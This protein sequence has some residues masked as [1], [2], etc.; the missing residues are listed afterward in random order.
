MAEPAESGSLARDA[1][2]GTRLA[3]TRAYVGLTVGQAA[4]LLGCAAQRV[5]DHEADALA[6]DDLAL[7]RYA[8][9]YG[10]TAA[11]LREG[12]APA[13]ADDLAR[14]HVDLARGQPARL[15]ARDR[16]EVLRFLTYLKAARPRRGG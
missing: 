15:S 8:R 4:K 5:R 7:E 16:A 13:A 14:V 2:V 9:L 12:I 10:V 11:A 1:T 3:Q 6:L